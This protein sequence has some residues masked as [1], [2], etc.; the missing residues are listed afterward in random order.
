M[1]FESL[2]P[3]ESRMQFKTRTLRL[4]AVLLGGFA[5]SFFFLRLVFFLLLP[6]ALGAW[7]AFL[8]TAAVACV[9][10]FLLGDRPVRLRCDACKKLILSNTPW[11]CG[12]CHKPNLDVA[13]YSF[14]HQCEHCGV[15]PK[16]YRCHHIKNDGK[17]CGKPIFFTVDEAGQNMATCLNIKDAPT[18]AEADANLER[19]E[20][21]EKRKKEHA[22]AMAELDVKLRGYMTQLEGP[23]IKSRRE[24]VIK[25]FDDE[26]DG[27][28]AVK[29][30]LARRL[31]EAEEEFKDDPALLKLA[32]KALED[33][34][35]RQIM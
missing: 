9:F 35:R 4:W 3:L 22:V 23:K 6:G 7:A 15:E 21:V 25:A 16:A 27:S 33:A 18:R 19:E 28:M 26:Y 14:L 20:M 31:R 2:A 11:V 30:H 29:E 17:P 12:V 1:I 8:I 32:K 5:V 34:A 24:T 10:Y 13:V